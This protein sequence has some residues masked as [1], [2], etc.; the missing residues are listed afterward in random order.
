M[1]GQVFSPWKGIAMRN[2]LLASALAATLA[3]P[4][5]AA[6]PFHLICETATGQKIVLERTEEGFKIQYTDNEMRGRFRATGLSLFNGPG[7]SLSLDRDSGSFTWFNT[8]GAYAE[9]QCKKAAGF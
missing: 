3:A 1:L 7:E 9:G 8:A 4:A 5:L 2:V 6:E